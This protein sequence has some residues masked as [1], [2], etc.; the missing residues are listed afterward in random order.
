MTLIQSAAVFKYNACKVRVSAGQVV[1]FPVSPG[2]LGM[3]LL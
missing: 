2:S 3:G 1:G